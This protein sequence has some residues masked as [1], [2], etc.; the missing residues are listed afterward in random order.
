MVSGIYMSG[1]NS[2]VWSSLSLI[3]LSLSS[4]SLSSLSLF[5]FSVWT[6]IW[7]FFVLQMVDG[8]FIATELSSALFKD[9]ADVIA[10]FCNSSLLSCFFLPFSAVHHCVLK[11]NS[12]LCSYNICS[13]PHFKEIVYWKLQFCHHVLTHV[14]LQTCRAFCEAKKEETLKTCTGCTFT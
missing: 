8:F 7:F 12:H 1:S 11:H 4:L 5:S 6:I 3:S 2:T 9:S 13:L 10:P 14:S